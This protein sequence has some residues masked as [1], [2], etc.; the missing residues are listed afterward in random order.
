VLDAQERESSALALPQRTPQAN[1]PERMC[2]WRPT[3]MFCSTVSPLN[4]AMFWKVRAMPREARSLALAR[5]QS[6]PPKRMV[7]ASTGKTPLNAFSI[8]DLPAPLGPMMENISPSRTSMSTPSRAF[9]PP[10]DRC[11]PLA[12]RIGGDAEAATAFMSPS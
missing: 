4:K 5:V 7:P 6:R 1:T 10:K 12:C 11:M 2:A 8:V 3:R 9:T